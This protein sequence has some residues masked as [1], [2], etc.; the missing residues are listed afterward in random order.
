MKVGRLP[1]FPAGIDSGR[2]RLGM[3]QRPRQIPAQIINRLDPY[4]EP[5]QIIGN[6]GDFPLRFRHTGVAHGRRLAASPQ[7]AERAGRR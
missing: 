2:P 1:S 4:R 5:N 3:L 7:P 6:A